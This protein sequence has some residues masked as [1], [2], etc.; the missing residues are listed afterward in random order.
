[1]S[2]HLKE[3]FPYDLN[4]GPNPY[5]LKFGIA[6]EGNN[7]YFP[8]NKIFLDFDFG[9]KLSCMEIIKYCFI[10]AKTTFLLSES[11]HFSIYP[12]LLNLSTE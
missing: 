11:I 1:M 9:Y 12:L 10:L 3:M 8:Q 5:L 4:L 2:V 7:Y 6:S